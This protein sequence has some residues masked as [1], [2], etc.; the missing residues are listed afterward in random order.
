MMEGLFL[1]A[2]KR[3]WEILKLS[4]HTEISPKEN[5]MSSFSVEILF[6]ET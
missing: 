6:Q 1:S 4:L 2:N 3:A 5:D